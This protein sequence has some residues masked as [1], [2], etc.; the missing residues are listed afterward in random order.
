MN[1]TTGAQRSYDFLGP[2]REPPQNIQTSDAAEASGEMVTQKQV[3]TSLP[4]PRWPWPKG[5]S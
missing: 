3:G 1:G 4:K 5:F 2:V